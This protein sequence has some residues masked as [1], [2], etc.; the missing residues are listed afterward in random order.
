MGAGRLSRVEQYALH[1]TWS[2]S[3]ATVRHAYNNEAVCIE[4]EEER[5]NFLCCHFTRERFIPSTD[6]LSW[7]MFNDSCNVLLYRKYGVARI[8]TLVDPLVDIP[9]CSD[10]AS[11]RSTWG[12]ERKDIQLE[13]WKYS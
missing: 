5:G 6:F 13:Y 2:K 9:Q 12:T 1:S 3:K 8:S 10:F 4:Q 7:P 11:C